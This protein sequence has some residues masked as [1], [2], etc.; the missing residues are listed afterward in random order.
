MA[1]AV[2]AL[3]LLLAACGPSEV[4]VKGR[5]PP[6]LVEPLPLTLGVWYDTDFREHQF[7]DAGDDK[8]MGS[9]EVATGE[10]QVSRASG[11]S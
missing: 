8:T 6:P 2:A 11:G 9:W 7:S 1:L 5:F 3:A 10:A 4:T